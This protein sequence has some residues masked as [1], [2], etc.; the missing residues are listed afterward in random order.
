M[1]YICVYSDFFKCI[2]YFMAHKIT[3][4]SL[5]YIEKSRLNN[6]I[7]IKIYVNS[8]YKFIYINNNNILFIN[9]VY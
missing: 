3:N 4:G 8:F 9:I 7:F 2:L 1:F 6:A 5:M